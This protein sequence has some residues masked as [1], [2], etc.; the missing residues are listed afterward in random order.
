MSADIKQW[1]LVADIGGTNARFAVQQCDARGLEHVTFYSVADYPDFID[2]FREYL[3]VIE[4]AGISRGQLQGVCM[5]IA[6]PV[7]DRPELGFTN[8]PWVISRSEVK[9]LLSSVPLEIINDFAAIGYAVS[10]LDHGDWIQV[11]GG[12]E[13]PGKPIV[14][15]GPGTGL[16]VCTLIPTAEGFSVIEGE[17][18]HVD[19]APQ[20]E[21]DLYVQAWLQ[22]KYKHVSIER[23]LSGAGIENIYNAL[24]QLHFT[25]P[26]CLTA[27]EI[28]EAAIKSVD[29]LAEETMQ[30]FFRVLGAAAG[31]LALIS[32]A[33]GGVYIA[34]GI[35]PRILPLMQRSDLRKAFESKGRFRAYMEK[36]PLRVI[37]KVDLG[38]VGAMQ[39]LQL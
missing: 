26:V 9:E 30:L 23:L 7:D 15:L 22:K 36:I 38:L 33:Q 39:R 37:T 11:G 28:T 6:C 27:A 8:S 12:E 29:A 13:K 34:G 20:D 21:R 35:L 5:A 14:V 24:C 18:G 4:T 19:F 10:G 32:G 2:A 25:E 3:A 31:N 17:G 1:N 16:G